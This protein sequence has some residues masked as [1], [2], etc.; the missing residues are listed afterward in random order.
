[1]YFYT[2]VVELKNAI[3]HGESDAAA[4]GL[5]G[6]VEVED[7]LADIVWDS[8]A[9]VGDA[10]NGEF[11]AIFVSVLILPAFFECY[12]ERATFG[13][14]LCAV[15]DDVDHSLLD[16][17]GV[18]V[19]EDWIGGQDADEG[20]VLIGKF[21]HGEGENSADDATEIVL[22]ELKLNRAAE[23]DKQL[24]DAIEAVNLRLDDIEMA[25]GWCASAGGGELALEQ[26]DVDNDSIDGVLNLVANAGGKAADGGHA[27]GKL[28]LGLDR[29]NGF[30]IVEGKERAQSLARFSVLDEFEGELDAS[31]SLSDDDFLGQR[32][33]GC[34]CM[35]E[36]TAQERFGVEDFSGVETKDEAVVEG[37]EAPGGLRD[38]D[39][40]LVGGEEEDAVLK[41]AENLIEVFLEGGEDLL[42]IAHTLTDALDL[43]GDSDRHVALSGALTFVESFIRG[44]EGVEL[45]ADELE[46]AQGDVGE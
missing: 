2:A 20:D 22:A 44:V 45:F 7:L 21:F 25:R 10:K 34:E 36:S 41:V 38:E 35:T 12:A 26:F 31:A 15:L 1:L 46:W 5:G 29:F 6:E 32:G 19:D 40:A 17:V 4:T 18:D 30:E 24:N 23:V 37:E 3:C 28:E 9:F 33:G 27:A 16:K 43:A 11:A 13:H 39:G 14:G 42:D 8:G